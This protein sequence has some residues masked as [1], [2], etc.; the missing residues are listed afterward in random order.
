MCK[1]S[2]QCV[3]AKKKRLVELDIVRGLCVLIMVIEHVNLYLTSKPLL[4]NPLF[5]IT[6]SGVGN[7]AVLFMFIMGMNIIFSRNNSPSAIFKRG[8]KIFILSYV[9]NFFRDFLPAFI[10]CHIGRSTLS[11][12][13][14]NHYYE[15]LLNVDILQFV[16]LAFMFI[17]LLR[18]LK[19]SHKI[20]LFIAFAVS[21]M[22]II[23]GKVA[24]T[25]DLSNW[26][27]DL[28]IGGWRH[29]Y[30]P[31]ISWI[32]FP[33]CGA[34]LA[35]RIKGMEDRDQ[36][37]R[38]LLR[39]SLLVSAV[40]WGLWLYY[41]PR[42]DFFGWNDDFDYYRQNTLA[43][44]FFISQTILL[45]GIS[46][47][48]LKDDLIPLKVN[49]FISFWSENILSLYIVSWLLISWTAW[50][51]TGFN[52]IVDPLVAIAASFLFV[53]ASHYTIKDVPA[54]NI[55]LKKWF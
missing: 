42:L 41:Y 47:F 16:G 7:V 31:F 24:T 9:F 44:V 22:T 17:A 50:V 11:S 21:F 35:R 37:Y 14:Y 2:F 33:I 27:K 38:R 52:F 40:L 26:A 23:I 54:I 51:I 25:P 53:V 29:N 39:W 19:I 36:I 15:T 18:S 12:H 1:A 43:N 49:N 48:A 46:Y 5:H 20:E 45:T 8:I 4:R 13:A 34:F 6:Q 28:I 55:F 32:A 30:F 10:G 3:D